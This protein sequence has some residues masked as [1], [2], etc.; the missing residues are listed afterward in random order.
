M[1]MGEDVDDGSGPYL[2]HFGLVVVAPY[3]VHFGVVVLDTP[4]PYRVHLAIGLTVVVK[5]P[6]CF[7]SAVV[8]RVVGRT[9]VPVLS[10]AAVP[11]V[12]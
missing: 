10:A 5:R 11:V 8:V 4:S 2:V 7:G 6:C 1:T 12:P 3:R 9:V